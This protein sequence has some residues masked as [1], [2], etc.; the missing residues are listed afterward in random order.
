[1]PK[2]HTPS[3]A[4]ARA[5]EQGFTLIELMV[6]VVI[7][8]VLAVMILP[9]IWDE[10]DKA[11]QAAGATQ[12][13]N[14]AMALEMFRLDNGFYPST[15]QGL[16]ALVRE[17]T[18]GREVPDYPDNGYMKKIPEDPWGNEYIYLSPGEHGPFDIMS[19]GADGREGGEGADA[20]IVS[21][22]LQ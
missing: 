22:E 5:R 2:R 17:P 4:V 6:V 21:W 8:S 12:I 15:E 11:R 10:P 20:D 3:P 14:I 18:T 1:M 7:L 9:N 19:Y 13:E 16:E